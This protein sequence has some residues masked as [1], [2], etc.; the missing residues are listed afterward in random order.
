M[1]YPLQ[2]RFKILALARQLSVTDAS[3]NLVFYVK[4]KAFKLKE[5]VTVFADASQTQP[6]Y[7]IN[8][9]RILDFSARYLFTDT[10]GAALGSVQR[11]GMKSIWKAHYDILDGESVTMTIREENAWTKV[12]DS[13]VGEIP[14]VGLFTGYMFHPAYLVARPSGALL[15]RL[16]KQPAFLEGRFTIEKHADLDKTEETR[17]LLSLIMMILLERGRG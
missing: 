11:K 3:G 13:V 5:A 10:S 16:E 9:A 2:V 12:I 4:Q 6:L 7:F 15:L 17:A 1:N 14:V 8:A